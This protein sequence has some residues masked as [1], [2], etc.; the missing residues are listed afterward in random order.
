MFSLCFGFYEYLFKKEE[1]HILIIGLDKAGKT[2]LLEK[3]KTL[4]SD[5][6]GLDPE[7]V[8]PTVGLNIA[9]FEAH[10]SPLVCWDL[11][12][13][14]GLR[15]IWDKY[16]GEAH[17]LL[18]VVDSA[19]PQRFDEARQELERAL[20]ERSAAQPRRA[21]ARRVASPVQSSAAQYKSQ[22]GAACHQPR[23]P[24]RPYP[25]AGSRELHGAPLLV[26]AN[27]QDLPGAAPPAELAERLGVGS[28]DTRACSVQAMSARSGDGLRAAVQW[29]VGRTLR[30]PRADLLQRRMAAG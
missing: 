13:Q 5:F 16:Y 27:K 17:A 24:C 18:F 25:G 12:G 22:A 21:D 9:R 8:L 29:L 30:S 3:M 26:A 14:A 15:S 11:G 7:Q 1:L 23:L 20:G 10:N 4:C 6:P 19:D 2:S 28:Y